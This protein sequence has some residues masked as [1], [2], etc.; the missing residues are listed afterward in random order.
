MKQS[1]L[2]RIL[3]VSFI[4]FVLNDEFQWRVIPREDATRTTHPRRQEF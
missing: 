3:Y 4:Q 1:E 2:E